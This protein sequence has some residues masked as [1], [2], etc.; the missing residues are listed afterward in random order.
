MTEFDQKLR[1][2]L[3]SHKEITGKTYYQIADDL[4]IHRQTIYDFRSGKR[5]LTSENI[6]R[7]INYLGLTI[8]LKEARND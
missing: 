7:V 8:E 6:Q 2:K 1:N 5:S 4:D 3:A